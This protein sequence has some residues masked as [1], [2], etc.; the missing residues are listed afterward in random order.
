MRRLRKLV[1]VKYKK[2]LAIPFIKAVEQRGENFWW[3]TDQ[4]IRVAN[5]NAT[6]DAPAQQGR[7]RTQEMEALRTQAQ[8]Q[9]AQRTGA[10]EV[11][12]QESAPFDLDPQDPTPLTPKTQ[13]DVVSKIRDNFVSGM[14]AIIDF[15]NPNTSAIPDKLT[16]GSVLK[17]IPSA[18]AKTA[19]RIRH[20]S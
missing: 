3:D 17:I 14:S 19:V 2:G 9:Q 11:P 15:F 12:G 6:Q 7:D 10:S 13:K 8:V 18:I 5:P 4:Q 16:M 1:S 20:G